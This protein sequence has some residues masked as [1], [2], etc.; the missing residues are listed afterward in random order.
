VS[1]ENKIENAKKIAEFFQTYISKCTSWLQLDLLESAFKDYGLMTQV[2]EGLLPFNLGGAIASAKATMSSERNKFQ[3]S[4][5]LDNKLPT[6]G[7][8]DSSSLSEP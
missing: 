4:E 2:N 6:Q 3:L 1:G 7:G 5:G 8:S